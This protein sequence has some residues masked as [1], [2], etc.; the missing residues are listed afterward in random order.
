ML[1][2][3]RFYQ[4]SQIIR[5]EVN[6]ETKLNESSIVMNWVWALT[7]FTQHSLLDCLVDRALPWEPEVPGSQT[8]TIPKAKRLNDWFLP[9]KGKI[10]HLEFPPPF[11]KNWDSYP[12]Q[13]LSKHIWNGQKGA[14][15]E[16]FQDLLW[17]CNG[18]HTVPRTWLALIKLNITTKGSPLFSSALPLSPFSF[19]FFLQA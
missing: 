9:E 1:N 14:G 2:A 13:A 5:Y 18:T 19:C 7:H 8:D 15:N 3:C 10:G 16:A 11:P 4:W 17:A 12:K 6:I